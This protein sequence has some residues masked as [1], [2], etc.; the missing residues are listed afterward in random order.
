MASR[1]SKSTFAMGLAVF[2]VAGTISFA[3][4]AQQIAGRTGLPTVKVGGEK[5]WMEQAAVRL[6]AEGSTLRA[7]QNYQLRFPSG[8]IEKNSQIITVAVREDFF[9]KR[10]KGDS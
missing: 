8:K 3:Q 9:R 4:G 5:V 2:T 1:Q 10:E 7:E 6:Y